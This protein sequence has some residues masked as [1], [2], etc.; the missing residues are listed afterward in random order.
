M[1]E[2]S[3]D[4]S[5]C[6]EKYEYLYDTMCDVLSRNTAQNA[7]L[8]NNIIKIFDILDT[9]KK[10]FEEFQHSYAETTDIYNESLSNLCDSLEKYKILNQEERFKSIENR[11][12]KI[13]KEI[14]N[15]TKNVEDKE[16]EQLKEQ[17]INITHLNKQILEIKSFISKHLTMQDI[18]DQIIKLQNTIEGIQRD[19]QLIKR[20]NN[21][22]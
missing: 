13:D 14:K 17:M 3:D 21:I 22:K 4:D 8:Q 19:L 2:S 1:D 12:D 18:K 10:T 7:S 9:H 5:E 11:L 20:L 6:D 15:S 16:I